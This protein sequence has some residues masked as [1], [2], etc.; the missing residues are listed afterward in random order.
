M[1]NDSTTD[2]TKS[3]QQAD[4]EAEKALRLSKKLLY[5][6]RYGAER[7]GLNV[8][9]GGF[10]KLDDLLKMP[11][12][13]S[14]KASEALSVMVNSVSRYGGTRRFDQKVENDVMYVRAS[15]GRRMERVGFCFT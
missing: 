6:L 12:L 11:M 1:D 9:E 8:K 4:W 2:T 10:I 14:V 7:E 13:K 3:Q 5:V 15:Y